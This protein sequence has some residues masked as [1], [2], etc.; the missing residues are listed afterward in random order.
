MVCAF[1][2]KMAAASIEEARLSLE[3]SQAHDA[4]VEYAR[5]EPSR[6]GLQVDGVGNDPCKVRRSIWNAPRQ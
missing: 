1:V 3:E 4:S 5:P 6:Y 2:A